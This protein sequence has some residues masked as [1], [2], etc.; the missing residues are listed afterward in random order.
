MSHLLNAQAK[1]YPEKLK[2]IISKI[3]F[4]STKALFTYLL[5]TL[6]LKYRLSTSQK[7][8]KSN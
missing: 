2:T 7:R 8:E 6:S 4:I 1:A 5:Y 3:L